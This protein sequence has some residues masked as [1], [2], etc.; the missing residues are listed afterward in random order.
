MKREQ[1]KPGQT[2]TEWQSA[3]YVRE[4]LSIRTEAPPATFRGMPTRWAR[5]D[6]LTQ[7]I[8]YLG[9]NMPPAPAEVLQA[10]TFSVN[11]PP[12]WHRLKREREEW[13]QYKPPRESATARV[14]E[15]ILPETEYRVKRG[16]GRK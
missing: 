2:P 1:I 16:A 9:T 5:K 12:E 3:E 6:P 13:G 11:Q 8:E 14:Q 15:I 10:S 4:A 7:F